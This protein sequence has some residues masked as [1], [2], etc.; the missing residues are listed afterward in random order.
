MDNWLIIIITLVLSAFFSGM[1]IAFVSSNN[2]KIEIDKSKGLMSARII[3]FFNINPPRF[4]GALLLGNN[5]A[6]V[7]YGIAMAKMLEP[8]LLEFLPGGW[9][10][11][12]VQTII[13]TLLILLV[14]EFLPKILFRIKPNYILNLF[15]IPVFV[16]YILFYPV[17]IFFIG[18]GEIIL[19][20]FFRIKAGG[21]KYVFSTVDLDNYVREFAPE[22]ARENEVQQEIQMFQNAIDFRNI[23]LR[24]CMVPR[25]EIVAKEE[26][27]SILE[28]GK[29]FIDSGFSKILIYRDSIDNIIGYIHTSDLF[30]NPASIKSIMRSTIF[31]PETMLA[32]NVLSMFIREH[33]SV[34]VVVD[35]FGGT[36]GLVTMEDIIEEIFGEIEDEFDEEGLVERQADD[37]GFVFS[38]RLEIDYLNE[39]Y[40]LNLPESE[41]YE[42]LAGLIIRYHES[43]PEL[44]EQIPISGFIFTILQASETRIDLVHLNFQE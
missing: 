42:T 44:R 18:L 43:I 23:K 28:L 26:N 39:K 9:I 27:Y 4:I 7:V 8:F 33:K 21:N 31:V 35:E 34:A 12:L 25:T 40:S 41:D 5:I 13:A 10:I 22:H 38:G 36:S 29:I 17:I 20:M 14:A 3:A 32:N 24:E 30:K 1:E 2:L 6:L 15:A 37:G 19:R 11:L 16:F